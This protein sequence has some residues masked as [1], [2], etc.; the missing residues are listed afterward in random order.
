ML[1]CAHTT[2][3]EHVLRS[4]LSIMKKIMMFL[5]NTQ[6][7][8]ATDPVPA[9]KLLPHSRVILS[10]PPPD[11]VWVAVPGFPK[12]HSFPTNTVD[13]LVREVCLARY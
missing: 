7:P 11:M 4:T 3:E 10:D 2:A 5:H 9:G 12:C 13:F 1:S 8:W 6:R